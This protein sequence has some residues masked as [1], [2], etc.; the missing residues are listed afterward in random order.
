MK[1][2]IPFLSQYTRHGGVT[3]F[4]SNFIVSN[5]EA[6]SDVE[7]FDHMG[8]VKINSSVS[9]FGGFRLVKRK[10][11]IMYYMLIFPKK[12]KKMDHIFLNPSLGKNSMMREMFY[13]KH[14]VDNGI[15]FSMFFHGWSWDFADKLDSNEKLRHKYCNLM[16]AAANVFVLGN[17]FK[18]K[19]IEWGVSCEKIHLEMTTVKDDF[20]PKNIINNISENQLDILFLGR[21]VKNKGVYEAV[22]AFKKHLEHSPNSK[23]VVAG[24]GDELAALKKYVKEYNIPNITFVGFANE[25]IKKDLLLQSNVFLFPSYSEGMPISIFEAMAHGLTIITRPVGGIP[26]FFDDKM[27]FMIDSLEPE[28]FT[29][30]LN[31]IIEDKSLRAEVAAYNHA[32][33][34]KNVSA[35]VVGQR[36]ICHMKDCM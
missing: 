5:L 1:I 27:G 23:F 17:D 28:D 13:A 8:K 12:I 2:Y 11:L 15:L 16:N 14:C 36:I 21:V 33:V 10:F 32:Y 24:D 35:S 9:T 7:I 4:L 20:I 18:N 31:Q 19:L 30:V 22:N 3:Q 6:D 25:E 34:K 29:D 26:D